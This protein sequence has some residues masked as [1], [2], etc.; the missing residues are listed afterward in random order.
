LGGCPNPGTGTGTPVGF[1]GGAGD[2][3]EFPLVGAL[4]DGLLVA[5]VTING[6]GPYLFA[7]DPDATM[8]AVDGDVVK[9]GKL[10]A[11]KGDARLDETGSP[12]QRLYTELLSIEIG[13]LLVEKRDVI[14]VK[15]HTFDAAGRTLQG[16]IGRD[17]LSDSLVFGFDRD[18]GIAY[19]TV[20]KAFKPAPDAIA[21]P[22]ELLAHKSN[23]VAP[24]RIAKASIG[25]TKEGGGE[26]YS[27]HLDLGAT[28]SQLRESRWGAA[29]LVARDVKAGMVDEVGTFRAVSKISEGA[30][31]TLGTAQNDHV[32]VM[33]FDDKRWDDTAID[34]TLGL[35]FFAPYNV[36]IDPVTKTAYLSKRREL[37]PL[38]RVTRWDSGALE[39]CKSAGCLTVRLID[40]LAGKPL[41]EGKTH[42]GL[43]LSITREDRAGG[44][45]LE[46]VL[47]AKGKPE[48]PRLL[49]NLTPN[50]DRLI[51]HLTPDF[52][53][54][55]L[56]V[57]DASPYP[58]PCPAK[59]TGCIDKLAR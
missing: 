53:G 12:Q 28:P 30:T 9:D 35:G 49:V 37:P 1:S 2:H 23:Q 50:A 56:E 29:K 58:R 25:G 57:V 24:R 42:P 36:W 17:I 11:T 48:L 38:S 46:V 14:V 26:T 8:S 16:V 47:E 4:E 40:P 43:V 15:P 32:V 18:Q 7:I 45:A 5:P 19:L 20:P 39:K 52:I 44:M 21:V 34:G 55:T 3:W 31:V 10:A 51:D 33:P 59:A 41:E 27:L 54:A 13:N 6:R 22:F